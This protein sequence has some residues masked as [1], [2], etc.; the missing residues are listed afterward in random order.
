MKRLLLV[1]TIYLPFTAL[2]APILDQSNIPSGS[3]GGSGPEPSSASTYAQTVTSGITGTL[4]SIE[5]RLSDSGIPTH[6]LTVE[7]QSVSSNLPNGD[8]LAS[9]ALSNNFVPH[10]INSPSIIDF[11][12]FDLLFVAGEKFAIVLS[13]S[14]PIA[15][16]GD[17]HYNWWGIGENIYA[18]GEGLKFVGGSWAPISNVNFDF[19]FS[20]YVEAVPETSSLILL[21][22]GLAGLGVRRRKR[23]S[24]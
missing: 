8:V 3:I 6:D 16:S 19:Y 12:A 2:A 10:N 17:P 7:L 9:I 22:L 23:S 5:L 20:T 24:L 14:Q 11:S 15:G 4:Q 21:G 1:F 13:S 18:D